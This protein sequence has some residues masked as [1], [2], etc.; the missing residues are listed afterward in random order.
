MLSMKHDE[1]AMNL[2]EALPRLC[3]QIRPVSSGIE[4]GPGEAMT[5]E[6]G[7]LSDTTFPDLIVVVG[8]FKVDE[9][10]LE[11]NAG[12]RIVLSSRDR[13]DR[14]D[15]TAVAS[16]VGWGG[17][18][19][20]RIVIPSGSYLRLVARNV[21]DAPRSF[22]AG[23][24][25]YVSVVEERERFLD[26]LDRHARTDAWLDEIRDLEQGAQRLTDDAERICT[27]PTDS[28]YLAEFR[29]WD[30][31]QK[32]KTAAKNLHRA[33]ELRLRGRRAV[34]SWWDDDHQRLVDLSE[35]EARQFDA[36]LARCVDGSP[37]R[38][39]GVDAEPGLAIDAFSG[40]IRFRGLDGALIPVTCDGPS[41]VLPDKSAWFV[42]RS[43]RAFRPSRLEID[44]RSSQ[45]WRIVDVHVD[46]KSQ[47]PQ[48]GVIPGDAFHP[49]TLDCF[50]TFSV[51]PAGGS[52][53]VK[54]HYV[55]SNSRGGR[56]G[57]IVRG[58]LDP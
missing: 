21:G 3:K 13:D 58:R 34:P 28:A 51:V 10:S 2:H 1:T 27:E 53:A 6:T 5:L 35:A 48:T 45:D 44:R 20:R 4:I 31:G 39:I 40:P 49:D 12:R 54:A 30:A 37:R 38:V 14:I 56:F 19:L 7:T 8:S 26:A 16:F 25:F 11:V 41:R 18:I 32:R 46:G 57:A 55:G 50:A 42:V 23:F 43:E 22:C 36:A 47:F 17:G 29:S 52:F 15:R 24:L 9:I 33:E